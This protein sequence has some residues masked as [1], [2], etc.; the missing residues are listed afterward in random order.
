MFQMG[1]GV[2]GRS[3]SMSDSALRRAVRATGFPGT[4]I[5]TRVGAMEGFT[6][7]AEDGNGKTTHL[8]WLRSGRFGLIIQF[9][10]TSSRFDV[11]L[12]NAVLS[13]LLIDHAAVATQS[14]PLSYYGRGGRILGVV[15]AY[16]WMYRYAVGFIIVIIMLL[17]LL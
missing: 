13:T 4:P 14:V 15:A 16:A 9:D 2:I 5:P 7:S 1:P 17:L 3:G 8:W 6:A 11:D 12:A 10:T